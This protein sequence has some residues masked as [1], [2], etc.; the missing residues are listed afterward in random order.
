M[1]QIERALITESGKNS[2]FESRIDNLQ[3]M[4]DR[5]QK[6]KLDAEKFEFY[7]QEVQYDLGLHQ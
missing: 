4:I 2:S 7:Q 1:R 3:D 6:K 5:L